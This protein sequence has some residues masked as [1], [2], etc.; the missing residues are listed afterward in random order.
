M[1]RT[2]YKKISA[3]VAF[4]VAMLLSISIAS[5]NQIMAALAAITG[6]LFAT[7]WK[8]KAKIVVDEREK[9]V[10]EKAAQLTYAIFTPML[11]IG[12]FLLLLLGKREAYLMAIGQVFAYL[13]LFLISLYSISVHFINKKLGGSIEE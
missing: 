4:F 12:A 8:L 2:H 7:I 11:A 10:Q 13:S 6:L 3:Y 1:N 5:G 9:T